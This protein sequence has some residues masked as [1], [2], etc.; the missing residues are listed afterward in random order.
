MNN[1]LALV[2]GNSD[3]IGLALTKQLLS[4]GWQ[5][6]ELSKSH[7]QVE[8]N[9]YRHVVCDVTSDGFIQQIKSV[10]TVPPNVTV[11]CAGIG[12]G[13]DVKSIDFERQVFQ[14][15]LMGATFTTNPGQPSRC[16]VAQELILQRCFFL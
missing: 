14:V 12:E 4:I 9:L 6:I 3:G 1:K 16:H 7:S 5:V 10:L 13:F 11:Y 15:N 8:N 2:I